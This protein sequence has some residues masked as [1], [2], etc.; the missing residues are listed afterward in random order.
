[1]HISDYSDVASVIRSARA[2]DTTL[3]ACGTGE[4]SSRITVELAGENPGLVNALVGLHPSEAAKTSGIDWLPALLTQAS[5]VGEI[6]LDPKYSEAGTGSP[7]RRLF[8]VQLEMAEK[9]RKPVQVHSRNAEAACLDELST[10]R[11]TSV[12]LHWFNGESEV[13]RAE[14]KGYFVSFGPALLE[15]KKLQRMASRYN[16][17]LVLV[18]SDGPVPFASLG[19]ANGPLSVPSVVFKLA[20]VIG[21][22]F[23]EMAEATARNASVYLPNLGKVKPTTGSGLDRKIGQDQAPL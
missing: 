13:G 14:E 18:E 8:V 15:S 2:T 7:Q 4:V 5:G 9:A 6:G 12:L 19:G 22:T 10:H 20:E 11:L 21:V 16:R 17:D 1:V 23:E 3:L